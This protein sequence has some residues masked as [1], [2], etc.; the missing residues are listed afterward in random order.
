MKDNNIASLK[1]Q[2]NTAIENQDFE[3]VEQLSEELGALLNLDESDCE[4]PEDFLLRIKRNNKEKK[5]MNMK[6]IVIRSIA[7]AAIIVLAISGG[8][9]A[10]NLNIMMRKNLTV[11]TNEDGSKDAYLFYDKN[12]ELKYLYISSDKSFFLPAGYSL[13]SDS[14]WSSE[15][16]LKDAKAQQY[17][18]NNPEEGGY[19]SI[20]YEK[21]T[22][23]DLWLSKIT[24]TYHYPSNCEAEDGDYDKVI[25]SEYEY[26]NLKS[27]IIDQHLYNIFANIPDIN[28]HFSITSSAYYNHYENSDFY[29]DTYEELLETFKYGS[30]YINLN[31]FSNHTSGDNIGLVWVIKDISNQREYNAK[32]G[33][34]YQLVDVK[35]EGKTYTKLLVGGD[36][37]MWMFTFSD[38][39]EDEIHDFIDT[40]K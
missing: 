40:L 25:A 26:E 38:L 5:T 2:I 9:I 8:A 19:D 12:D 7:A 13:L 33:K 15:E 10:K 17:S 36:S 35:S 14:I 6:K 1:Q 30:G 39:T 37:Y 31:I 28:H 20:S 11:Q 32:N 29:L 23:D 34:T 22:K 3:K 24:T 27:L 16:E 18:N 21:P 4:M